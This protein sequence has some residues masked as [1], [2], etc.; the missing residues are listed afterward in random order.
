MLLEVKGGRVGVEREQVLDL[1]RNALDNRLAGLAQPH[2]N[3]AL[4]GA[5]RKAN[6]TDVG[7]LELLANAGEQH[8]F[9]RLVHVVVLLDLQDPS[10]ALRRRLL[11]SNGHKLTSHIGFSPARKKNRSTS[12]GSVLG[13]LNCV[14][15]RKNCSTESTL[16]KHA[17][18][19]V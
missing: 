1:E 8:L 5:Q 14:Y 16:A 17:K 6:A 11:T 12:R 15:T 13:R 3:E 7:L 18:N 19:G 9:P 4:L 2:L 10:P